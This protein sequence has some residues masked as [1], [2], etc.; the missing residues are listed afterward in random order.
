MNTGSEPNKIRL[1]NALPGSDIRRD[2]KS[3]KRKVK[4]VCAVARLVE[5]AE[6]SLLKQTLHS[7]TNSWQ[8]GRD[9]VF[10]FKFTASLLPADNSSRENQNST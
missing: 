10:P 3:R 9:S 6:V 5:P 7:L 1:V 8:S 4:D 2:G